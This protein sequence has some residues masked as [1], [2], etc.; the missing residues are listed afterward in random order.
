MRNQ[1]LQDVETALASCRSSRE[2]VRLYERTYLSRAKELRDTAEFA[3][4]KGA[5]SLLDFLDAERT[6]RTTQLSYR[7][8]V[9]AYVT[10]LALLD[11]AVSA[12]VAP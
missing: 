7:K 3:F 6:Y 9:A 10:N 5:T 11:A 12:E 1:V 8:E 2:R 4:Q